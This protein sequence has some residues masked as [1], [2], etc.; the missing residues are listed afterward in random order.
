MSSAPR[1]IAI[2]AASPMSLNAF[3]A[4]HVRVL[5]STHA[6]TL[7]AACESSAVAAQLN[8]CVGFA[9]VM[10]Q[11]AVS[12][13]DDSR[14]LID[15]VRLFRERRFDIVQ[16][17]TPK[18]GLLSMVAARLA[19][20]PVR[21][22]WFT[23]QV[24]AT[25]TGPARWLLKALDRVLAACATDMLADSP[26][27]RDFLE[28]EGVVAAGRIRVLGAG[29][30]CGVDLSRFHPDPAARCEI[31][32]QHDIPEQ[33]VVCLYLGRLTRDKGVVELARAFAATAAQHPDVVC[34]VVGPDEGGVREI[35]TSEL[36]AHVSRVRFV[37]FTTVPERYM[38]ASDIFVMP[39]YREG[40]GSSVIEAAG[41]GLPAIG[42][43]IYGLSDAIADGHTGELV[44]VRDVAALSDAISRMATDHDLRRQLGEQAR[45]RA[46]T[47]FAQT[48]L[49]T[50]LMDFYADCLG[51]QRGRS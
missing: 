22:H 19:G 35:M 28:R 26:S 30:V 33:A 2:V 17:I 13:K 43:A 11:R 27:Q 9:P 32:E 49:T 45:A 31:R 40:F 23:G 25:K 51:R 6:V 34:L 39:S 38:A 14:A 16:S 10:I 12:L 29:S 7:V 1:S 21:I 41:C 44:P 50:A 47:V 5:S 48:H 8:E 36:G 15:L 3:M 37:D 18:A 20:V 46:E 24:W 42:T 4:P